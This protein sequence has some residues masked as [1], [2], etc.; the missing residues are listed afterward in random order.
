MKG[1]I[2]VA[3][4]YV[5]TQPDGTCDT[6]TAYINISAREGVS[7][8]DDMGRKM[9]ASALGKGEWLPDGGCVFK[10]TAQVKLGSDFYQVQVGR[11]QPMTISAS[12]ARFSGFGASYGYDN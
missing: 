6:K 11:E 4:A 3:P 9:G 2:K 10:F 7:I 5:V 8:A 12:D 1:Q